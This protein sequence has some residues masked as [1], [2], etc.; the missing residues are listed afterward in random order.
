LV[1]LLGEYLTASGCL[2]IQEYPLTLRGSARLEGAMLGLHFL[3]TTGGG[4]TVSDTEVEAL[5]DKSALRV[6]EVLEVGAGAL[7]I[8]RRT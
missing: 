8:L 5:A 6:V 2:V 4:R 7:F 3:L 1:R